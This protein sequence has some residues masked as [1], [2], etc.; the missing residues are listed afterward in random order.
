MGSLWLVSAVIPTISFKNE[1]WCG[2]VKVSQ[3][4]SGWFG[5]CSLQGGIRLLV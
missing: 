3:E 1:Y 5:F 2:D 4:E